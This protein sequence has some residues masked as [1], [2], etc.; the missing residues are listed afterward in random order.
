MVVKMLGRSAGCVIFTSLL[1]SII[2][3][4]HFCGLRNLVK[5]RGRRGFVQQRIGIQ[6]SPGNNII[7]SLRRKNSVADFSKLAA[8]AKGATLLRIMNRDQGMFV[9][10]SP[11]SGSD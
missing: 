10:V 11:E 3:S 8:E 1:V 5:E 4:A 6:C 9:V 7:E 2:S